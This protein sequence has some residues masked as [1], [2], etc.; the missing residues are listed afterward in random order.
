MAL[1]EV[2][3]HECLIPLSTLLIPLY[4]KLVVQQSAQACRHLQLPWGGTVETAVCEQLPSFL[5]RGVDYLADYPANTQKN[6]ISSANAEPQFIVWADQGISWVWETTWALWQ[7]LGGYG[8]HP[9]AALARCQGQLGGSTAS[10]WS[11]A[12]GYTNWI[13]CTA[14]VQLQELQRRL[15]YPEIY[16]FGAGLYQPVDTSSSGSLD[17]DANDIST[18]FIPAHKPLGTWLDGLVQALFR[19][20]FLGTIALGLWG[21]VVGSRWLQ[22]YGLPWLAYQSMRMLGC[23]A[24]TLVSIF[25]TVGSWHPTSF[26]ST[27]NVL[28]GY[29]LQY[30]IPEC[31]SLKTLLLTHLGDP[32]RWSQYLRCLTPS[33]GQCQKLLGTIF[34]ATFDAVQQFGLTTPLWLRDKLWMNV[35]YQRFYAMYYFVSLLLCTILI[36]QVLRFAIRWVVNTMWTFGKKLA[37]ISLVMVLLAFLIENSTLV[38]PNAIIETHPSAGHLFSKT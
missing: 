18:K 34:P 10:P 24:A 31:V 20:G 12:R 32:T 9:S 23:G 1:D 37:S 35:W 15:K 14:Q 21:I 2:G 19:R 6:Y 5:L 3:N 36:V 13:L 8:T 33:G 17:N 38:N 27:C 30:K 22:W 26:Q 16:T 25:P 29:E 4:L 11:L 28:T 7:T